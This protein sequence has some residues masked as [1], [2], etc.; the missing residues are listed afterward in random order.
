MKKVSLNLEL[1]VKVVVFTLL[2]FAAAKVIFDA[3]TNGSNIL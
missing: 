1:V 3:I 2:T